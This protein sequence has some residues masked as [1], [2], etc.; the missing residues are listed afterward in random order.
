MKLLVAFLPLLLH[1]AELQVLQSPPEL[2]L[3]SGST[4]K[5]TC[6]VLGTSDPYM[7]RYRWTA[8]HGLVHMFTSA[9]S[10][11]VDRPSAD[12][13]N[14]SRPNSSSFVLESVGV[15]PSPPA[16]FYCSWSVHSRRKQAA[17][18]TKTAPPPALGEGEGFDGGGGRCRKQRRC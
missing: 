7:Y 16:V 3:H 8:A 1:G 2:V 11:I 4:A 15:V 17:C 12:G 10:G 9:G 5:I 18:C 6:S 13:F 14:A